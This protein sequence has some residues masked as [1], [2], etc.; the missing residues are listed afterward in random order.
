M[1]EDFEVYPIELDNEWGKVSNKINPS[2]KSESRWRIAGMAACFA[3]VIGCTVFFMNTR[4][5]D[6]GEM[7]ELEHFY[8]SEI[9]QKITLIKTQLTDDHILQD[10]E[11]M[12]NAFAE[13]KA[14]LKE[15]VDN[16]EV[17]T[18]M[19]ENYRLKL[20]ILEE[21]LSELEKERSEEIL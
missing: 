17:V 5:T 8:N 16:E 15:N 20:Q 6:T 21:I 14:D 2:I 9:N 13:L 19:M 11:D 1:R 4:S 10:L 7:V 12:D 3:A 18:A